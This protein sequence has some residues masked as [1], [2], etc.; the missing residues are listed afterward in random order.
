MLILYV[1]VS[2]TIA[3]INGMASKSSNEAH[4]MSMTFWNPTSIVVNKREG[5]TN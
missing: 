3:Q 1:H 5:D 2:N 4:V